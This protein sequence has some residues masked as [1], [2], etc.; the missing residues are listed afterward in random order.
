MLRFLVCDPIQHGTLSPQ[1]NEGIIHR[2]TCLKF[3][4]KSKYNKIGLKIV[5][6]M[7]ILQK[8]LDEHI[9]CYPDSES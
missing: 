5:T 8:P 9:I 6:K 1:N 3:C 4:L 2:G 7:A